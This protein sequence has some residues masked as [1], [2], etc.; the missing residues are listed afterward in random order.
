MA[1]TFIAEI[2]AN[3]TD[4]ENLVFS[5]I[6]QTY[7]SLR[8]MGI[9]NTSYALSQGLNGV[10]ALQFNEQTSDSKH[11]YMRQAANN[12][13]VLSNNAGTYNANYAECGSMSGTTPDDGYY[14]ATYIIDIYNYKGETA[15]GDVQ[16]FSRS[17]TATSS[18]SYSHTAYYA[19]T[20]NNGSTAITSLQLKS[21]FGNWLR[22]SKF[23]L[24]GRD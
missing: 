18:N 6:P 3:S 13:N 15:T 23:S 20:Y 24:Y 19:G 4:T 5:G 1:L 2:D 12:A 8:I 22:Y 16:Y 17:V 9:G 10:F 14:P 21:G 11:G 7:T